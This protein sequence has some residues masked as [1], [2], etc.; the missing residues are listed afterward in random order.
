MPAHVAASRGSTRRHAAPCGSARFHVVSCGSTPLDAA[1]SNSPR[2]AARP[3]LTPAPPSLPW[4][5]D[6]Y[7]LPLWWTRRYAQPAHL[8][9]AVGILINEVEQFCE[10][11]DI[12]MA[13]FGRMAL[14]VMHDLRSCSLSEALY[15]MRPLPG[16]SRLPRRPSHPAPR[17]LPL[18]WPEAKL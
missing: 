18:L 3:L 15:D 12:V 14:A 11:K 4:Q 5:P 9:W 6:Y 13:G 7:I 17:P 1:P 16:A 10:S 2:I 8:W